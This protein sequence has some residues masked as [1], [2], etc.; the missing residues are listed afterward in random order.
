[1]QMQGLQAD[2]LQNTAT[3]AV[4]VEDSANQRL[5]LI[6]RIL[7][8]DFFKPVAQYVLLLVS[9]HQTKPMHAYMRGRFVPLNATAEELARA[10]EIIRSVLVAKS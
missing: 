7:A 3:G 2:A 8:E 9:R 5:E 10:V 6:A 1:M 4:I